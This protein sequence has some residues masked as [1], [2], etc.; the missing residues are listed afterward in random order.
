MGFEYR[1]PLHQYFNNP[2]PA[3]V[4]D[5]V[6]LFHC[7]CMAVCFSAAMALRGAGIYTLSQLCAKT[8]EELL[9]LPGIGKRRLEAIYALLHFMGLQ[10]EDVAALATRTTSPALRLN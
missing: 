4:I 1:G 3:S 10:R 2:N 9:A 6:S 7:I 5:Q 8:D